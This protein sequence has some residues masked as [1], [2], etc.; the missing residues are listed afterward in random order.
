MRIIVISILELFLVR[1]IIELI[2]NET[3]YASMYAQSIGPIDIVIKAMCKNKTFS[4]LYEIGALCSVLK[5][6]I[7]SI[8]PNIDFRDG[9]AIWNNVFAPAP[10]LVANC[11][12]AIL[13]SHTSNEIGARE[14]NNGAW[15]PNHFVPLLSPVVRHESDHTSQLIS[16]IVVSCL[17]RFENSRTP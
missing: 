4:E 15:S 2:T 16:N 9:M 11:D 8:Y 12:I 14:T 6:Y 3:Y 13:W 5:C 17:S 7:R 10:P 1:T